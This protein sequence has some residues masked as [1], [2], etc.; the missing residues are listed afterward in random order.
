MKSNSS[1]Q[2]L[3][4]VSYTKYLTK[5]LILDTN[6]TFIL[7]DDN[8]RNISSFVVKTFIIYI[9]SFLELYFHSNL[10]VFMHN[11]CLIQFRESSTFSMLSCT[12][13]C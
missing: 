6:C 5:T 7:E 8:R 9:N 13:L 2:S 1:K 12:F 4:S 3:D 10:H 11:S